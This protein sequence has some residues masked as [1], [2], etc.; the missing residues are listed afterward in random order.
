M[1]SF[2]AKCGKAQNFITNGEAQCGSILNKKHFYGT[3]TECECTECDLTKFY[4]NLITNDLNQ[5]FYRITS[6]EI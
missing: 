4:K 1:Q 3:E 6:L 2:E 5:I